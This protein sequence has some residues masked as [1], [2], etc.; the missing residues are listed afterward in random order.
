MKKNDVEPKFEAGLFSVARILKLRLNRDYR[1]YTRAGIVSYS[2]LVALVVLWP[3]QLCSG[4]QNC[5]K[6]GNAF[7]PFVSR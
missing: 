1:E 4:R 5:R 3:L 2:G 7:T 6:N